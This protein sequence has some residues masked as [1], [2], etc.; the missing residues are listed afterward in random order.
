MVGDDN[1]DVPFPF[2]YATILNLSSYKG[3]ILC[4][5]YKN[6]RQN[7]VYHLGLLQL[8]SFGSGNYLKK[9]KQVV[10]DS[11][12]HKFHNFISKHQGLQLYSLIDHHAN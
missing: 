2:F 11:H 1:I 9:Q 10:F 6:F 12:N 5:G 3:H 8:S 7:N 4:F